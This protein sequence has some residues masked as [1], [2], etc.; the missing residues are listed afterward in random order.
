M[1]VYR[2]HPTTQSRAE[3]QTCPASAWKPFPAGAAASSGRWGSRCSRAQAVVL[4][5]LLPTAAPPQGN[6]WKL[7]LL[8]EVRVDAAALG[9]ALC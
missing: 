2:K 6:F 4:N 8:C 5:Q 3:G 9:S 1:G 7:D